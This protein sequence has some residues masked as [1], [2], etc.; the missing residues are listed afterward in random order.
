VTIKGRSEPTSS[1]PRASIARLSISQF[2][3]NEVMDE[4]GVNY[5]V[6]HCC[7]LPQALEVFDITPMDLGASRDKSFGARIRAGKTEHLM[8]SLD[9]FPNDFRTD[10]ARCSCD[11]NLHKSLL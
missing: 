4:G 6:R 2:C 1:A 7:P 3:W 10:K 5:S 8:S 9:E 11:K